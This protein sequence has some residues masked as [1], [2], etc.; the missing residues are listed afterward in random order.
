[1]LTGI[2]QR[3]YLMAPKVN[4][5]LFYLFICCC[6][7]CLV[8]FLFSQNMNASQCQYVRMLINEKLRKDSIKSAF[9]ECSRSKCEVFK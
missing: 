9:I 4:V 7:Y 1:M 6:C 5:Q 8:F 3:V 2:G